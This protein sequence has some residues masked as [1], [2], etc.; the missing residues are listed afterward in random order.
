MHSPKGTLLVTLTI[1]HHIELLR[2]CVDTA[3]MENEIAQNRK[4][5]LLI[6]FVSI[7]AV[8]DLNSTKQ[9]AFGQNFTKHVNVLSSTEK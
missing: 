3:V 2:D 5:H 8:N 1:L 6:Q 4:H 7:G 9:I